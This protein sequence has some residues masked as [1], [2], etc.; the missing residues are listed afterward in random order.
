MT[1]N[2][3]KD[4]TARAKAAERALVEAPRGYFLQPIPSATDRV[5]VE[6]IDAYLKAPPAVRRLYWEQIGQD[7]VTAEKLCVFSTRMSSLAVREGSREPIHWA[8]A[9]L[10]LADAADEQEFTW[11]LPPVHDAVVR[12]G[13]DPLTVFRE[14][15]VTRGGD[16]ARIM[17]IFTWDAAER[18]LRHFHTA[19]GGEGFA[20]EPDP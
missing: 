19:D 13:F 11:S 15:A 20:Y 2:H 17:Q 6:F 8:L 5:L 10:T 14:V 16:R 12:L 4:I 1:S 18:E 9:A 3:P 7:A